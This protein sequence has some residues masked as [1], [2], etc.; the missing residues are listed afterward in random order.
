MSQRMAG[1]PSLESSVPEIH[2]GEYH[3]I[4]FDG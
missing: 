2:R 3:W 4:G 1:T